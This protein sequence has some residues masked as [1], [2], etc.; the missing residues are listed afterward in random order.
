MMPLASVTGAIMYGEAAFSFSAETGTIVSAAAAPTATNRVLKQPSADQNDLDAGIFHQFHRDRGTVRYHRCS[1]MVRKMTRQLSRHAPL[2]RPVG[3]RRRDRNPELVISN[4]C[5]KS[6]FLV[7]CPPAIGR[8]SLWTHFFAS[9]VHGLLDAMTDGG[10]GVAFFSPFDNRRYFLPWTPIRVIP[11]RRQ[12]FFHPSRS[13]RPP[14]RTPLDLAPGPA[15]LAAC[16]RLLRR[17]SSAV[18]T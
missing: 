1:Q 3:Q 16:A 8:I 6:L 15:L 17:R 13:R 14:V 2:R 4:G 11:D 18:E 10:L 5:E 7:A 12:P 9:G